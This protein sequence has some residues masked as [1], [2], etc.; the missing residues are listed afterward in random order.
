MSRFLSADYIFPVAS[1]PLKNG[2]VEVD[3]KGTVISLTDTKG[4]LA[5][6]ANI[7]FYNGILVPGFVNSH[8]HLELSHLKNKFPRKTKLAGFIR[9]IF[10]LR[11]AG[12]PEIMASAVSADL[13]LQQ[14]GTVATGDISNNSYTFLIKKESPIRYHTFVEVF[15]PD[16]ARAEDFVN[17]GKRI[18]KQ[19]F[20]LQLPASLTPHAPYS[21]SPKLWNLLEK[22]M[23]NSPMPVSLHNQE[24]EDENRFFNQ[25]K[26]DIFELFEGMGFEIKSWISGRNSLSTVSRYLPADNNI[27]LVHNTFTREKDIDEI[28][29]SF[30]NLFFI[31]CPKSNLFIEDCLPDIGM[32]HNKGL[33]ICIGTDSYSSNDSLSVL[34]EIKTISHYFPEIPLQSLIQW[35]SLNGAKALNFNDKIG[36]IEIGKRPGINLI[37]DV[38]FSR[39]KITE[40]SSVKRI[41]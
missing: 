14:N 17:N 1:D 11:H 27:L 37:R 29:K 26:G 5:E 40:K 21:M 41:C 25:G 8:C 30:R 33:T 31:L 20:A 32:M 24:S 36:S 18:L 19:A 15:S 23:K 6:S 34:E 10:S 35:A 39:M 12:E 16:S 4:N 7:E 9:N 28:S 38:D 2:I 13:E 22:E 3:D